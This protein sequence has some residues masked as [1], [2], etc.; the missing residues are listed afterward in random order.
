[1]KKIYTFI[2]IALFAINANAK[3]WTVS[4]RADKPAQYTT[5]QAAIN[6]AQPGDTILIAGSS[7][8]YSAFTVDRT[9]VFYGEGVNNP[10]GQ[11]TSITSNWCYLTNVNSG[12]GA[13]GSKFYGINFYY[14]NLQGN[15]TGQTAG[16]NKIENVLFDRCTFRDGQLT[17]SNQVYNNI[18]L[19]NC[20][21]TCNVYFNNSSFTNILITNSIFSNANTWDLQ[22]GV[23][24]N[25]Q[26]FVRNCLFINSNSTSV[27][28]ATGLVVENCIFYGGQPTGASTSTFNNNLTFA[29][30]SNA[31]PYGTNVGSGNIVGADPKFTSFPVIG[32]AFSWSYDF[33]LQAGSP[34]IGTGT[35]GTNIGLTGGNAPV[36]HN[37]FGNSKLPVVTSITVPVSSVPVGGTLQINLKANTRK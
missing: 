33:A 30:S 28:T 14:M 29:N 13:S 36:V 1:M 11:S 6:A 15:F 5:I 17:F 27:F 31:L 2:L 20:Y 21:F 16:Q 25:G 23:N 26:V 24:L 35:N 18:T 34:A 12:I 7:T 37:L 9:L 4:N 22:S 10:D 19:R 32:G 8:D 3:V